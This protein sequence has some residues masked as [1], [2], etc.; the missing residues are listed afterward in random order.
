MEFFN[1]IASKMQDGQQ[2]N[3]TIRKNGEK[4]V[5]SMIP[6]TKG[7]KD[8]AVS[9]LEPLVLNGT[10]QE[11]EEQFEQA[12]TPVEKA[13]SLISEVNDFEKR[14]DEARKKTEMESKK[15]KEEDEQK[16]KF[17]DHLNLAKKLLDEQKFKDSKT[18]LAKAEALPGAD[19]KACDDL[20]KKIEE[21]SGAGGL[22]G[23]V[24]DK[25]D[26]KEL[27]PGKTKATAPAPAE[28]ESEQEDEQNDE[29]E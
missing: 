19:K 21:K 5:L 2:L 20:K 25:S 14:L 17:L 27:I 26:G 1:L 6:D 28:S 29:E 10:P 23:G 3:M 7:V 4:L 12:L 8:K 13:F 24:E 18:V 22:F 11:F 16:Q 9:D 15:K